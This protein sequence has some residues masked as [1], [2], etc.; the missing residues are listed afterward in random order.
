MPDEPPSD[1]F[2]RTFISELAQ[3]PFGA[4]VRDLPIKYFSAKLEHADRIPREGGALV[5]ANHAFLGLD[6]FVL[7]ALLMRETGRVPRFLGDR[8]LFR[9]P[10]LAGALVG[11]GAI[12]GEPER[13]VELLEAGE[14]VCVYPGGVDDSFKTSQ[15]PEPGHGFSPS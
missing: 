15:V 6:G 11:V 2:D 3:T 1:A 7:G 8:N 10:L 14:L 13:A 9:I 4:L 12:A 5:V